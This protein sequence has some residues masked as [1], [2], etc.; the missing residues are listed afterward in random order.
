M[1]GKHC[2]HTEDHYMRQ[3]RMSWKRRGKLFNLYPA[4][5]GT[6]MNA[7]DTV[8]EWFATL[9]SQVSF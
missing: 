9:A 1:T 7:R 6:W 8:D 5:E 2:V 3:K 4:L